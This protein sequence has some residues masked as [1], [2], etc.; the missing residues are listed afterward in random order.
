MKTNCRLPIVGCRLSESKD[1]ESSRHIRAFTLLE[2]LTVISILGIIAALVV[3]ALKNFGKAD[4]SLTAAQQL[5]RDVGRARQLAIADRTTI[6]MVFVPMSFW[7]NSNWAP[8]FSK[9]SAADQGE[10]TNLCVSQLSGYNFVADGA[11]GDQPGNHQWHYLSSW[12]SLPAGNFISP[13]KFAY[14]TQPFYFTDPANV[15][16][17]FS[18]NPFSYTN[19]IPF[20]SEAAATNTAQP[21]PSLPYIAFNYLGQLV[22]PPNPDQ[23][24]SGS[25]ID[26]PLDKGSVLAAADPATKAPQFNDGQIIETPA[27]NS[28]NIQYNVVHIDPLTGR[29]T[30]LFHPVQ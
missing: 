18:I 1:I 27:G 22:L 2:L 29:A 13:W 12:Q 26:I 30:L 6:Y 9:L 10:V 20:P 3:P 4:A 19:G 21:W 25:G 24:Y 8:W 15:Q 16:D 14:P 28:T 23:D 17:T 5:L 11:L 7:T